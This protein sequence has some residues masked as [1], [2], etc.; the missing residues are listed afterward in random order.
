M[1]TSRKIGFGIGALLL[2]CIIGATGTY[3]ITGQEEVLWCTLAF[4][5]LV[6]CGCVLWLKMR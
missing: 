3:F 2:A 6:G 5:V 1:L 4:L